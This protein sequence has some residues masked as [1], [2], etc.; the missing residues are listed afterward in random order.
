MLPQQCPITLWPACSLGSDG[1]VT[2]DCALRD[3]D[4]V[5]KLPGVQRLLLQWKA[6]ALRISNSPVQKAVFATCRHLL[7][8]GVR[9]CTWNTR[10]LLGWAATSQRSRENNLRYLKRIVETFDIL[11]LQE[12]HGRIEH[13]F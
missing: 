7:A 5:A 2:T 9:I 10:G 8:K 11:C 6:D 1:C 3:T 4:A 13:I 12:T